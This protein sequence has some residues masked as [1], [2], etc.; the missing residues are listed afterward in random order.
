MMSKILVE[1]GANL[2]NDTERFLQD[3]FLVYAFEPTPELNL[4]LKNRF[5]DRPGYMPIPMAVDLE[6]RWTTFNI[7]GSADWGCSSIHEFNPNIHQEWE[8]RPDFNT[9]DRCRVMT[10]RL[11]TFMNTYNIPHINYLWIDAQ[12][13]DFRVLQSLGDRIKDVNY[14]RCEVALDVNLYSNVDNTHTSV[15]AWLEQHGFNAVVKP[16]IH[17]KE[18]DVLFKKK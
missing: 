6:N 13:N 2:G 18:A 11:D 7:A 3:G 16:H 5:K 10:I 1:V 8:G 4:H 15:V 17:N 9:T 14:G 12:G